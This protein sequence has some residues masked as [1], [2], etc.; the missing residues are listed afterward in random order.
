LDDI[1]SGSFAREWMLENSAGQP[2]FK[3]MRRLAAAHPIELVGE[4]LRGM[5]P[6]IAEKRLV[7]RS[8]N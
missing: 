1:Q 3:T 2:S 8:R 7:N 6:W 4:K 5:M